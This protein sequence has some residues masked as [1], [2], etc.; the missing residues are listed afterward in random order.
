MRNGLQFN[1]L[2]NRS[3]R[4]RSTAGTPLGTSHCRVPLLADRITEHIEQLQEVILDIRTAIFDLHA[5]PAR[6]SGANLWTA[7]R[8][9]CRDQ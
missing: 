2:C 9:V 1:V 3:I 7:Y 8:V 6:R 4:S 5:E